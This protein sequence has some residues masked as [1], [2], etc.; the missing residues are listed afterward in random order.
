VP[1]SLREISGAGMHHRV[2]TA[3]KS[4]SSFATR[5][6]FPSLLRCNRWVADGISTSA[7]MRSMPQKVSEASSIIIY[8]P[9]A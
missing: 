5:F 7:F 1:G 4:I 2:I 6:L 9:S 3:A 8:L